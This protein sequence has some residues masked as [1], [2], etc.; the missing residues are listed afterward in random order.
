MKALYFEEHAVRYL[1]QAS[2]FQSGEFEDAVKLVKYLR[3]GENTTIKRINCVTSKNIGFIC[4]RTQTSALRALIIDLT[5][6][7]G[8]FEY[9]ED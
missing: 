9:D 2:S 8:M 1:A 6:M 7:N 4:N 3:T 5:K